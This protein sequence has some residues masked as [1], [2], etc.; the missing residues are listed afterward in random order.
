MLS[1]H[2]VSWLYLVLAFAFLIL[3]ALASA[4]HAAVSHVSRYRY[5]GSADGAVASPRSVDRLVERSRAFDTSMSVLQVVSSTGVVGLTGA[6]FAREA[7]LGGLGGGL[8]VAGLL[9]LVFGNGLPQALARRSPDV[10][11]TRLATFAWL[12]TIVLWPVT[13]LYAVVMRLLLHLLRRSNPEIISPPTEEEFAVLISGENGKN[14]EEVIEEDERE[15]ID[16]ILRLEDRTVR[17]IMVPRVDIVAIP[18]TASLAD[19]VATIQR[20]GHSRLPVYSGSIDVIAGLLYAKDLFRFLDATVNGAPPPAWSPGALLRPVHIVPESKPTNDLLRE[21]RLRKIHM[22]LV[23]DEYGGTAGLVTIED[24]LE[25]IVGEIHDEHDIVTAPPLVQIAEDA[26][27]FDGGISVQ[28]V[29]ELLDLDWDEDEH[30]TIAGLVHR[31]LGSLPATGET[32]EYGGAR[33][34]VL[35]VERHRLKRLRVDKLHPTAHLAPHESDS[36]VVPS[37]R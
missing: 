24:V 19:V 12:V 8:V 14:F 27:V 37:E 10:A 21:L 11:A 23:V 20:A 5:R 30:G 26:Y 18:L 22:A 31:E 16:A 3:A 29:S 36:D 25:E 13:F 34:T 6:V 15:M 2:V 7:I 9:L 32:L 28:D 17:D 33:I 35:E 4:V 1:V